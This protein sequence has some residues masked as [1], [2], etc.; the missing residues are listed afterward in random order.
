MTSRRA[1]PLIV[2]GASENNLRS[3]DVE[4]PRERFVVMTGVSGSG[5][6]TLAHQII[7]REG[8]RRFVE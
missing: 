7:C 6:S 3:L 8:Q 4:I 1:R 2:R 5:K